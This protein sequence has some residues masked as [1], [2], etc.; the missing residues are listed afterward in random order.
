MINEGMRKDTLI[1]H[2]DLN[3]CGGSERLAATT[4]ETLAQIGF[5]VDLATFTMP[6][7]AKIQRQF[8]INLSGRIRKILFTNLYSVLNLKGELLDVNTD[9]Y[10]IVLNTHGDLLPF[11][12][13]HNE[14]DAAIK[15]KKSK[16]NLTYYHYR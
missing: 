16:I 3:V 11:Y 9:N 12:E 2:D 1:V 15:G 13:K 10:D 5:N 4:I 6:D 8:G 7:L 14:N